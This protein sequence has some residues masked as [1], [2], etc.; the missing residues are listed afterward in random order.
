MTFTTT[1]GDTIEVTRVSNGYDL[2]LRNTDGD[3][4]A[5]AFVSDREGKPTL[6]SLAAA[7]SARG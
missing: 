3:S 5:T 1:T 2:H 4:V 7:L 6:P